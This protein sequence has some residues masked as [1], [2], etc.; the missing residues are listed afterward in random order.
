M[1]KLIKSLIPILCLAILMSAIS[2]IMTGCNGEEEAPA[3][4]TTYTSRTQGI[5]FEKVL[6]DV[7][8]YSVI[9][10]GM[11]TDAE[12]YAARELISHVQQ[13]TGMELEY[14]QDSDY[15]DKKV[16]SVGRTN[17]LETSGEV[18][19]NEALGTDGF[20]LKNKGN[21]LLICGSSDRGTIYGVLDFL[22]YHLGVKF[23]T[24]DYTYI[25]A[26][27]NAKVYACDRTEIPAFDY[28]VY[29]DAYAFYNEYPEVNVHHRFTS[30][31]L[32]LT[33]EQGGNMKWFQDHPTHNSLFWADVEKY[34]VD[35]A[36]GA[37]Y[38]HAFSNDNV[39]I[40]IDSKVG[41]SYTQYAADLCYT[42]G[43]NEDG[44]IT[45]VSENGTP[46]A[47]AMAIEG[48]KKVIRNDE[49]ENN[50][51]MFGQND[52]MSRL[53]LCS[54]CIEAA[55]KYTDTGIMIRFFNA[56]AAEIEKFVAEEGIDRQVSVVMF[57]Y[58]YSSYAPV[59]KNADGEFVVI[60]ET[61]KP[62]E[63]LVIRI[64]PI[65]NNRYY[66]Y[67][68]EAQSD[69]LYGIDYMDKWA[70]ISNNFMLW[71][72][73]TNV[74]RWYWYCPVLQVWPE[75]LQYARD[76]GVQYT[77]LQSTYQEYPIYQTI[78]ERYVCSK[79]LWNPDYDLN[80]LVSEFHKYYLGDIAAPYVDEYVQTVTAACFEQMNANGY[81]VSE[82]FNYTNKGML[83]SIIANLDEAIAK[84]RESDLTDEEK[85]MYIR[86]VEL[87]KMQPRYMYLHDYMRYETDEV[88]MKEDVEQFILD[89][90]ALGGKWCHEGN[91]FDLENLVIY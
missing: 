27:E 62:R 23:L 33:E 14:A 31:Y 60:D 81:R 6:G 55:K 86:R 59:E 34:A 67:D 12:K 36:L 71:E 26:A 45:L 42:D 74:N 88:Q 90:M 15:T 48:M 82:L 18:L 80:E 64:A 30:E 2:V 16:I 52:T 47:I 44:S 43:I 53:C 77:M 87:V 11:A 65:N 13:I 89:I 5:D 84:I 39:N 1:K 70:A 58:Q 69:T 85:E 22:E 32:I 46:T 68:H 25:P 73:T 9:V 24:A 78:M 20:I 61:C 38:T 91:L 79:L 63:D 4:T 56:L 40:I 57:A 17:F 28:R 49:D 51:Y 21:A 54:R 76:M 41:G 10:S 8:E 7:T 66:A 37:E 83:Q 19:D 3:E 29:L 72:Y 50:Y 35:G 75:K